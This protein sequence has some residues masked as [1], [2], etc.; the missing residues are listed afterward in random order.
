MG[1]EGMYLLQPLIAHSAELRLEVVLATAI[2]IC[3]EVEKIY[4]FSNIL[5]IASQHIIDFMKYD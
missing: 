5:L 2:S 1:H 3:I 4:S